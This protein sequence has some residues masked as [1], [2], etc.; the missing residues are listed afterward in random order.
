MG[1]AARSSNSA[2]PGP[3]P[4][5]VFRPAQPHCPACH[6][7]LKVFG[8]ACELCRYTAWDCLQRFPYQAPVLERV[9]DPERLLKDE[10]SSTILR[11]MDVLEAAYP[12]VSLHLC[13]TRLPAGVDSR[14]FG[15]W[16]FNASLAAS[17][18]EAK[19][20]P[21]SM[22]LLVDYG[23][24]TA[25]LTAGY[26]LEVFLSDQQLASALMESA[27]KFRRRQYG[28]ALTEVIRRLMSRL[29]TAHREALYLLGKF[30]EQA[31]HDPLDGNRHRYR[32]CVALMRKGAY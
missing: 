1:I 6:G 12:Q 19:R 21:W 10:E 22:L 4:S 23:N 29:A 17:A 32:E 25:S 11:E 3:L 9:L 28:P 15:F 14:E 26:Q 2:E 24:S 31:S 27:A 8:D 7:T 5:S 18:E 13:L 16:L 20:R 30:A